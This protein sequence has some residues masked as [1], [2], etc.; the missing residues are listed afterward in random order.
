MA[1]LATLKAALITALTTGVPTATVIG[2]IPD[3]VDATPL[4]SVTTAG[5]RNRMNRP[6]TTYWLRFRCRLYLHRHDPRGSEE[7]LD[8][9]ALQ[10]P[11]AIDSDPQLSGAITTGL[12]QAP[13]ATAGITVVGT[14]TLR[15]YDVTVEVLVKEAYAGAI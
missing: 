12:A 14:E 6:L 11:D 10:I 15:A 2:H 8:S 7:Q 3:Q 9:L 5:Y 1:N 13:D 4:I